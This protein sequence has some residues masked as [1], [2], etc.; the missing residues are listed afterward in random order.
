[1]ILPMNSRGVATCIALCCFTAACGENPQP[2]VEHRVTVAADSIDS[3]A[4][5]AHARRAVTHVT[6]TAVASYSV[7][8]VSRDSAGFVV[9]LFPPCDTTSGV[10]REGRHFRR[11]CG[12][13]DYAV[14]L[15][16]T[17]QA[18]SVVGGQ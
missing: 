15:S 7:A 3:G 8:R 18:I 13:G 9:L 4:V 12:G 6:G 11:G 16:P 14:R 10:D 5:I 17:G 1:M 2:P